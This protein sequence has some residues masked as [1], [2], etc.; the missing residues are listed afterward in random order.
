MRS[1]RPPSARGE[2][3]SGHAR[4]LPLPALLALLVVVYF[5]AGKLGL[6][7]ALVHPSATPIWAPTGIAIASMLTLGIRIW[8]VLF[9]GA[10]LVNVTTAGSIATCLGI[11]AGNTLE[12]VIA[13]YLVNRF[14]NGTRV[15][16]RVPDIFKFTVLAGMLST[17]VSATFGVTSLALVL[18]PSFPPLTADSDLRN[19]L[20]SRIE[21]PDLMS[22]LTAR[23][24]DSSVTPGRGMARSEEVPPE[25]R[26]RIT[27]CG[28]NPSK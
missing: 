3:P 17:T 4:R 15:F 11:A 21:A 20:I 19:R 7:L 1:E 5:A 8:P 25:I 28:P 10:F 12:G 2:S 16:D 24:L 26:Q 22:R 13:A 23:R 6:S 27:S 18:L 14:A 9:L